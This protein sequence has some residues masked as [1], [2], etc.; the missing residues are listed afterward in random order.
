MEA[1]SVPNRPRS[2]KYHLMATGLRIYDKTEASTKEEDDD[3][4]DLLDED[5][6]R[7]S[8][9]DISATN[10]SNRVNQ[11]LIK[12]IEHAVVIKLLGRNI[13]YT[14]LQNKIRS[15]WRPSQPF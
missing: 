3:D 14:T 11:L 5:I 12:D 6:V 4:L 2:W 9:N 7:S 8:V 15:L 10:F 1:V 13:G